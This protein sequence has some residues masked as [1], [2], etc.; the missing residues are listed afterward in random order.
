MIPKIIHQMYKTANNLPSY[1]QPQWVQSW[2]DNH[3][4]WTY[5]FW[6]DSDL[7]KL[8]ADKYPDHLPVFDSPQTWPGVVR[9]DLGRLMVL[10]QF[11]GVYADLDY[12]S[13]KPIDP[14]LVDG[15]DIIAPATPTGV[16]V[17]TRVSQ[18]LLASVPGH[19]I[20]REVMAN[21]LTFTKQGKTAI[22]YSY[23]WSAFSNIFRGHRKDAGVYTAP[24]EELCPYSWG[25]RDYAAIHNERYL[26]IPELAKLHPN[27]YAMHFWETGWGSKRRGWL[28]KDEQTPAFPPAGLPPEPIVREGVVHPSQPKSWPLWA[29]KVMKFRKPDH[30]GVGDTV[31]YLLGKN[32]ERYKRWRMLLTGS[33]CRCNERQADLNA[34]YPYPKNFGAQP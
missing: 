31:K 28:N 18:A 3:P 16:P 8:A 7:R 29:R 6:T 5:R 33:P 26:S 27:T 21:G 22:T 4:S 23:G 14:L 25:Q 24:P 1:F 2:K 10:D 15:R 13:L 19:P 34:A 11:G 9:G 20:L 32:G 30:V 12:A 17:I